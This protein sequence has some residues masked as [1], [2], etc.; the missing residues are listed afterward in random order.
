MV[1]TEDKI[2]ELLIEIKDNGFN[3]HCDCPTCIKIRDEINKVLGE[4]E[5]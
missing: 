2:I 1:K 4:K 5:K 3:Y